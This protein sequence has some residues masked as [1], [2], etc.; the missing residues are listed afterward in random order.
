MKRK[1]KPKKYG[2]RF[3]D[4]VIDVGKELANIDDDEFVNL[5][6]QIKARAVERGIKLPA[7]VWG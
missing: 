3:L 6:V 1:K 2:Q 4:K 7:E 5:C